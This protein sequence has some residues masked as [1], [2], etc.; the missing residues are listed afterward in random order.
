ML[1]GLSRL[2][3]CAGALSTV[4]ALADDGYIAP[5]FGIAATIDPLYSTN[6]SFTRQP[7]EDALVRALVLASARGALSGIGYSFIAGTRNDRFADLGQL[8]ADLGIAGFTF[9]KTMGQ[10]DFSMAGTHISTFD[11]FFSRRLASVF[12]FGGGVAYRMPL[13]QTSDG[14]WTLLPGFKVVRRFA[15]LQTLERVEVAPALGLSGPLLGGVTALGV[16]YGYRPF[17]FANRDDH[18]LIVS[19]RWTKVLN[20]NVAFSL[21]GKYEKNL[22]NIA[23]RSYDVFEI[24]PSINISF[25]TK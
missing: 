23:I 9:T 24:G 3:L 6:A 14:Q 7:N 16:A 18:N 8:N 13:F 25:A 10:F 11:N 17:D 21:V 22:S 2:F 20:E 12:D 5:T 19:G 15:D 1:I 4:P